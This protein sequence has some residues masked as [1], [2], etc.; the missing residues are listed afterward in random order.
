MATT[1]RLEKK[2]R[3][4]LEVRSQITHLAA[5]GFSIPKIVEEIAK[6][7]NLFVSFEA[8]QRWAKKSGRYKPRA[9][10]VD[11]ANIV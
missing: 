6:S 5:E 7:R 4:P 1:R 9:P 2:D 3:L 11:E 10:E 8:A